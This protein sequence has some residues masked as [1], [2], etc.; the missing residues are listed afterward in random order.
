MSEKND[1]SVFI[2]KCMYGIS[3]FRFFRFSI[4][5]HEPSGFCLINIDEMYLP[6]S[7]SHCVITPFGK[8]FWISNFMADSSSFEN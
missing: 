7:C 1:W 3:S 5:L 2:L 4:H 8:S 6:V